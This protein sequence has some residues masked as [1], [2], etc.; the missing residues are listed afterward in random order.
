MYQ[1]RLFDGFVVE[2]ERATLT[3]WE[4]EPDDIEHFRA[5]EVI[6]M[7]V[8]AT[9]A[10]GSFKH[11]NNGDWIRTNKLVSHQCRVASGVMKDEIVEFF[12]LAGDELPFTKKSHSAS[13][14]GTPATGSTPGA[15]ASSPPAGSTPVQNAPQHG[16]AG[17]PVASPAPSATPTSSNTST[18]GTPAHS[19]ASG[20]YRDPALAAFLEDPDAGRQSA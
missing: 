6:V 4:I 7:V 17:N 2:K 3:A 8:T 1:Q 15:P 13:S 12:N 16:N 11:D 9:V 18:Q 10:G 20:S 14:P 19:G 5:D